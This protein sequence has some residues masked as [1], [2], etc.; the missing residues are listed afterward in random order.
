MNKMSRYVKKPI[1]VM[2]RQ[3]E[4]AMKVETLEGTFRGRKGDY[5]VVGTRGEKYIVRQDIFEETYELVQM[6][7][8]VKKPLRKSQIQEQPG[9]AARTPP[10][11]AG[12][13]D[14]PKP[15]LSDDARTCIQILEVAMGR[16]TNPSITSKDLDSMLADYV[17]EEE[18]AVE[19][20]RSVR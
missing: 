15:E 17:D 7:K 5:L 3:I 4:R 8:R 2:A 11:P 14:K 13:P 19:L 10:Q 1:P 16:P 9:G 20:V 12:N 6:P 18:D